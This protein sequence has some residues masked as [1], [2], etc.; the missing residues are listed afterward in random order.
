MKLYVYATVRHGTAMTA[1]CLKSIRFDAGFSTAGLLGLASLTT[2]EMMR[3]R[4]PW[5]LSVPCGGR[6]WQGFE[7]GKQ[8]T[9]TI[10]NDMIS[11]ETKRQ[12]WKEYRVHL[13]KAIE[14]VML[15]TR[16]IGLYHFYKRQA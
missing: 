13:M 12:T 11:T 15:E 10:K 14:N 3:R 16:K 4:V 7:R 5:M 8:W 1:F 6:T 9:E 2:S